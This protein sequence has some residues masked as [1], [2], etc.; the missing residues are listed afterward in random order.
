VGIA[1]CAALVIVIVGI[2][3]AEDPAGDQRCHH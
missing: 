2:V 1:V 3:Y